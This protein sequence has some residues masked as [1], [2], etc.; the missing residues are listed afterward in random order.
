M[1]L[2]NTEGKLW[3]RLFIRFIRECKDHKA[4]RSNSGLFL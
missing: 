1:Q 2:K 4:R 3:H